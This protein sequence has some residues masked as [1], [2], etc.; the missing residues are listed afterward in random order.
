MIG[1]LPQA[2][3]T[4]LG[5]TKLALQ[6]T[7]HMFHLG[8]HL[9]FGSVFPFVFFGQECVGIGSIKAS[10]IVAS[11]GDAREFKNARQMAAW[12]GLVPKQNSSGGKQTLLGISKRGDTF[13]RTL[14]IHGA[15]A[16]L[17]VA[18][19]K[20]EPDGWLKKLMARR[21]KNIAAVALA[22]KNARIVWALLVKDGIFR[23]DHTASA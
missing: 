22:N 15:R 1:I 20:A 10:A 16:V 11:V 8:A 6:H 13:L 7:E 17:R 12:I 2:T 19:N 14:L 5:K 23:P 4:D 21:N 3:V 18:E 9:R